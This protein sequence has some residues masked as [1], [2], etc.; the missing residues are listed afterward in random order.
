MVSGKQAIRW[1][2][3]AGPYDGVRE[4]G[5]TVVRR[6]CDHTVKRVYGGLQPVCS[7]GVG[8]LQA[9]QVMNFEC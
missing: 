9:Y 7:E 5:R 4:A 6:E 8:L 1:C 3:E 2:Q